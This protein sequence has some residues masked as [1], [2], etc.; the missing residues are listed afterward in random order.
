MDYQPY[1]DP[2]I[3][4]W[5]AAFSKR[6]GSYD[7]SDTPDLIQVMHPCTERDFEKFFPVADSFKSQLE[8]FKQGG[9]FCLDWD[10]SPLDLLGSPDSANHTV[11]DIRAVPCGFLSANNLTAANSVTCEQNQEQSVKY[12]ET[13][14]IVVYHNRGRLRSNYYDTEAVK[15]ESIIRKV[16]FD[17][18]SPTYFQTFINW[19]SLSD[20]SAFLQLGQQTEQDFFDFSIGD[21]KPSKYY[22][23]PNN[24]K[25]TS[26]ALYQ[27][28]DV[29]VT[30]R[31]TY[32]ILDL[33]GDVGGLN[34]SLRLIGASLV[35]PFASF[36]LNSK[37]A[38]LL[39]RLL[40]GSLSNQQMVEKSGHRADTL[41]TK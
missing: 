10:Q 32:S 31:Q 2:S 37:L 18:S 12:L 15:R 22:T 24:F 30:E 27:S 9:L 20:E 40:Q 11:I 6:D 35:S 26:I 21:Q 14:D 17:P 41:L 16:R 7:T 29:E 3:V 19:N 33:L 25:F 39:Q 13:P 36:A 38:K 34:D 5:V 23:W 4:Q 1:D 28:L 8:K